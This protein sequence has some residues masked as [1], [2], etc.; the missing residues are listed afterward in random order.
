MRGN[1]CPSTILTKLVL[2]RVVD[3]SHCHAKGQYSP[4]LAQKGNF[5]PK[6]VGIFPLFFVFRI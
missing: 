1:F 3:L 4:K 6:L 5:S 2:A